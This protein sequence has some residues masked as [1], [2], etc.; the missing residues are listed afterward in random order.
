MSNQKT[1]LLID[2]D[3]MLREMY[4]LV[5]RAEGIDILSA[6]DGEEGVTILKKAKDLPQLILL[7][8]LMPGMSG[9]DV[10]KIIK[11]NKRT[12]N[13]PVFILTNLSPPEKDMKK[14]IVEKGAEGYLMKSEYTPQKILKKIKPYLK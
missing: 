4:E 9:Y 3:A 8:I 11:K 10:L 7:D 1:I 6:E 2:D 14:D 12:R 13:I 5:F